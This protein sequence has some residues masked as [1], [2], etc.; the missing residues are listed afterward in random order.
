MRGLIAQ[1]LGAHPLQLDDAA[2][3]RAMISQLGEINYQIIR[4]ALERDLRSHPMLRQM[5]AG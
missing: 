5:N 1:M 4:H 2:V 3:P